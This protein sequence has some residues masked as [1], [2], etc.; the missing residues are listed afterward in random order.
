MTCGLAAWQV[1]HN[2]LGGK[3]A[4]VPVSKRESR[5]INNAFA[6]WLRAQMH[7][8]GYPTEPPRA[9]GPTRLAE[10]ADVSLSVI[11]RALNEGRTPDV[12]SLRNIG[13]V[14][15]YSLGE[16]LIRA[17]K[18]TAD[19]LPVRAKSNTPEGGRRPG[20]IEAIDNDDQLLPEAKKHLVNQYGLLIRL[21][22]VSDGEGRK[23]RRTTTTGREL[24]QVARRPKTPKQEDVDQP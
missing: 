18:A 10:D 5:D 13:H 1:G 14:L 16:M 20:V 23:S 3:L 9:G 2:G 12:D 24:R 11:S 22:K 15:G 6:E 21:Q 4:C 17:G 19:E 8:R 7:A